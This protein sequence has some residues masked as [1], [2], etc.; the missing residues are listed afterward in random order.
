MQ[1]LSR[2]IEYVKKSHKNKLRNDARLAYESARYV[3]KGRIIEAEPIIAKD[4]R[5]ACLYAREIL[6]ERWSEAEPTIAQDAEYAWL[7]AKDLIKGR[8]PEAEQAIAKSA[9]FSY[10]Y[11]VDVVGERFSDGEEAISKLDDV[12]DDYIQDFFPGQEVITKDEI[13]E[14]EWARAGLEGYFANANLLKPRESL[15]DMVIESK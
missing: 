13:S 9:Q 8:W 5:C 3:R 6:K 15:L 4:A 1:L 12:R 11:A 14:F 2:V 7:Y 10:L